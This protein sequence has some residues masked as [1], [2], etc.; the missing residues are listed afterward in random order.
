M[1]MWLTV[2]TVLLLLVVGLSVVYVLQPTPAKPCSPLLP[3]GA[4]T[5]CGNGSASDGK[6]T[7]TINSYRIESV[8][9][10]NFSTPPHSNGDGP[11]LLLNV[12][13]MNIAA[14]NVSIGPGLMAAYLSNGLGPNLVT[15]GSVYGA[16]ATFP[17]TYPNRTIDGIN[18]GINI[19]P[20][21][22]ADFWIII[23]TPDLSP[24]NIVQ[25]RN[26]YQLRYVT[27]QG[28]EFD[29]SWDGHGAYNCMGSNPCEMLKVDFA[30]NASAVPQRYG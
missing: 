4:A 26:S 23:Y 25:D 2:A 28:T 15:E 12:T 9:D 17:D 20:G 16:N 7:V 30:I 19:A 11:F 1:R 8:E 13:M 14:G 27:Y 3:V 18:G 21:S 24:I 22:R 29:G 10:V 6:F 5:A